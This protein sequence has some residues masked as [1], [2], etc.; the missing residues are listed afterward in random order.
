MNNNL[1]DNK[2]FALIYA[3]FI[4][5]IL[6]GS[7]PI[8]AQMI[9][10]SHQD[11]KMQLSYTGQ[12]ENTARA[13]L[14]DTIYWFKRQVEQP[15]RSN[16]DPIKYPYADAAFDPQYNSDP[17]KSDT[18][19]QSIGIVKEYF[20]TDTGPLW[21]RYEVRR[22]K[23]PAYY[24][25]D[26]TAV[27]DITAQ[28]VS[29]RI[30]GEGLVW[31]IESRGY[32]YKKLD[33][34]KSF[35][36]A[37]NV[38]VSRA[39]VATEIRRL[40]LSLNANAACITNTGGSSSSPKVK[41]YNNGRLISGG[42]NSYGLGVGNN[43]SGSPKIYSG[44]TVSSTKK[45]IGATSEVSVFGVSKNDIKVMADIVT[46]SVATLPN[47]LPQMAVIYIDLAGT[48][49]ITFDSTHRLKGGGLL[50]I[51]GNLYVDSTSNAYFSGLIY[52]TGKAYVYGPAM[53]SGCVI[54]LT[55]LEIDGKSDVAEIDYDQDIL[56]T[57]RQEL[58]CYRE[59]KASYYTFTAFKE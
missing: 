33:A 37:P 43:D 51:D 39:R 53:I 1:K 18:I 8:A 32:I 10:I 12:A 24:P 23:D 38:I 34:G 19:D 56:N 5:V 20:L 26:S 48:G 52:V 11:T 49:T 4:A 7:I 36:Q 44:G 46:T 41:V 59:N 27:Q 47:P 3:I 57:V 42:A 9:K 6:L 28:R 58:A 40:D 35:N 2:G 21:A 14:I 13:G 31:Y 54:A 25:Y 22:Q 17:T 29:G 30:A 16:R 55:G 45:N 15:V 50:F